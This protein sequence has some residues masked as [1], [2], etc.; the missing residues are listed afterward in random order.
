MKTN[1]AKTTEELAVFCGQLAETLRAGILLS[2]GLQLLC[3]ENPQD[4][5]LKTAAEQ[6]AL[7]SS[8]SEA[9]RSARGF[10]EQLTDM[11]E[12][13]ERSGQLEPVLTSLERFYQR[14]QAIRR[15][16]QS[17]LFYP[18]LLLVMMLAVIA[19]LLIKVLPL[20]SD[21]FRLLGSAAPAAEGMLG[22]GRAVGTGALV[23]TALAAAA[24]L[25][26]FVM[27]RTARGYERFSV[28]LVRLPFGSKISEKLSAGRFAYGLSLLLSSGY[29]IDGAIDSLSSV[30]THPGALKKLSLCRQS[31]ASG[32]SFSAALEE[33]KIFS[34]LYNRMLRLGE[35]AG[36]L[37]ESARKVAAL[38]DD[39]I[40]D[41][42]S[43]VLGAIEPAIALL[44]ALVVGAVLLC[45]VL[46]LLSVI[47]AMG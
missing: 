32:K 33:C 38:Y 36:T 16:L 14:E 27:C 34:P 43:G 21:V 7:G 2:D 44:L 12:V 11:V 39:E 28:L 25:A 5:A 26:V 47:T 19:V 45:V 20:F 46:P 23:M 15:Q 41:S 9:L 31:M 42:L 3:D 10:P 18:L 1:L 30:I 22:V 40:E 4:A 13:G 17:A 37:N 8:L 6:I 24:A 35:R 29:D